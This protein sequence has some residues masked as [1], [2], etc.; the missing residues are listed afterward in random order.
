M[1]RSSW[2]VVKHVLFGIH[3]PSL[4]YVG[5]CW[6][7]RKGVSVPQMTERDIQEAIRLSAERAY[8]TWGE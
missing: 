3:S 4:L 5:Q 6:C 2:H 1:K 7:Q 8:R